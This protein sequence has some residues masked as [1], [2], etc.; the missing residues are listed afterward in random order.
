[1]SHAHSL[2]LNSA[3]RTCGVYSVFY[4]LCE[5][6]IFFLPSFPGHLNACSFLIK[7]TS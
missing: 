6:N 4:I 1:M 7:L 3:F 2:T 5:I